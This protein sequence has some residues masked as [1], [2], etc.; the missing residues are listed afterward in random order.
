MYRPV[1][2]HAVAIHSTA[3]CVCQVRLSEYGR[4]VGECEAVGLLAFDLVVRGHRAEQDLRQEQREHHP[5]VLR[6]GAH[7]RRDAHHR[8]R[9]GRRQLERR[10]VLVRAWCQPSKRD[11]GDQEQHAEDRPHR[12]RRRRVADQRLVRPVVGVGD[13][14]A[15][16]FA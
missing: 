11:A 5:E 13:V 4:Y 1:P 9:I 7:R 16:P 3:S 12:S 2:S 15:R 8:E 6:G 10:L 14:L